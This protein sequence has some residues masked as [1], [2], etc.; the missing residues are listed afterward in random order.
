MIFHEASFAHQTYI[1]FF[2]GPLKKLYMFGTE[3]A[4]RYIEQ[5]GTLVEQMFQIVLDGCF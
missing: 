4:L 5:F 2:Q 1:I 3:E